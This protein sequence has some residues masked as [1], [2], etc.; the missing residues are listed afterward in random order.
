M[1]GDDPGYAQGRVRAAE[2]AND[3]RFPGPQELHP[4][5]MVRGDDEPAAF[6]LHR[7]RMRGQL[8]THDVLPA[9]KQGGGV[10]SLP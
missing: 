6:H 8:G 3:R 1:H 2:P 7:A 10:R 9:L 4:P 5:R